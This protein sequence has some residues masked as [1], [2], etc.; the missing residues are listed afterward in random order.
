MDDGYLFRK[1]T[2]KDLDNFDQILKNVSEISL[3]KDSLIYLLEEVYRF[4][5]YLIEKTNYGN[6]IIF[7]YK[8]RYSN[9]NIKY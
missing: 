8:K 3:V 5:N 4:S 1:F 6:K 9:R 7:K 2:D